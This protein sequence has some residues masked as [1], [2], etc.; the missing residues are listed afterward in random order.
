MVHWDIEESLHY[1]IEPIVESCPTVEP[2]VK[3]IVG[4]TV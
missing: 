1:A 3:S 2:I 4:S